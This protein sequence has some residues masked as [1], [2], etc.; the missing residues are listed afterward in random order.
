M[1]VTPEIAI[2]SNRAAFNAA[3]ARA[4]LD[5][6]RP[7]LA[8]NAI[9]LTG[10]DSALLSGRQAQL[11][12][13]KREFKSPE[14]AIYTRTPDDVTVSSIEPIAFE[15]GCWKGVSASDGHELASGTYTAKWRLFDVDWRIEAELY[16]TLA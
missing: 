16:L 13:W 2:R 6:I 5:A 3:L 1:I 9:L 4:D 15:H 11:T 14:R 7:I 8:P 10:T 12:A